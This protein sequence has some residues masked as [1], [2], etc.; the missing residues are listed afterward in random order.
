MAILAQPLLTAAAVA[1]RSAAAA[2]PRAALR[3]VAGIADVMKMHGALAR[4]FTGRPSRLLRSAVVNC[5]LVTVEAGRILQTA[6]RQV[7]GGCI[8]A[9]YVMRNPDKLRHLGPQGVN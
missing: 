9:L 1:I 7:E 6:A 8:T 2:R 4:R 5:G 3:S